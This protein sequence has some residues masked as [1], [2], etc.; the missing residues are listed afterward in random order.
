M[1]GGSSCTNSGGNKSTHS[2]NSLFDPSPLPVHFIVLNLS[3]LSFLESI[4]LQQTTLCLVQAERRDL[5]STVLELS[6]KTTALTRWLAENE[7]KL[8]EGIQTLSQQSTPE[9]TSLVRAEMSSGC[10]VAALQV[11]VC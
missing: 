2:L 11:C 9:R 3:V 7:S 10:L 1:I 4:F 6:G 5:E 8:P